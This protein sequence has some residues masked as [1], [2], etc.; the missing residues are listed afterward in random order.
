VH[1][2]IDDLKTALPAMFQSEDYQT[3]KSAIDEAFQKKQGEAF[4]ALRDKAAAKSIVIV[5]TPLG[6]ALAPAEVV[7]VSGTEWRLG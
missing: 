7:P 4:A 2:L 6:F 1:Q 3:R 5:R